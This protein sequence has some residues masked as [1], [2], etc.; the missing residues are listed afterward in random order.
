C[1]RN[2]YL[3]PADPVLGAVTRYTT[4]TTVH[5]NKT[6]NKPPEEGNTSEQNTTSEQTNSLEQEVTPEQSDPLLE[7]EWMLRPCE[8]Y[9]EEYD[10]CKSIRARFHQYFIFGKTIDCMQWKTDYHNCYLWDKYKSKKALEALINSEKK[11]RLERLQAHCRNNVWEK[12]DAPP[13]NWNAPL[14]K[15]LEDK[16]EHSYLKYMRDEMKSTETGNSDKTKS[17]CTIM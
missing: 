11:R 12:R 15:W 6:E 2:T 16:Y 1:P 5:E 17:S 13:E 9:K 8:V 7:Y 4:V 14:P 10:D 3:H